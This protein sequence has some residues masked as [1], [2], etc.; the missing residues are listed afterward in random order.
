MTLAA[1][2]Q[3]HKLS[4]NA[5]LCPA[6]FNLVGADSP[7]VEVMTDFAR[8]N[9]VTILPGAS[10]DEANARMISRGVRLLMVSGPDERVEG[11]ISARDLMGEK[12]LQVALARG[13]KREDLTV[14]DLMVPTASIDTLNL[15]DVL[16]ARVTDVLNALKSQGRQHIMV[17]DVDPADGLPRVRG[18][19]SAT[20]IGR[21]LGVPVLGFDLPQTFAEIE[22]ALAN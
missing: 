9:A 2:L 17:E 5:S 22:A 10:L 3:T 11:L 4:T 20:Q 12:P 8:V 14:R 13:S 6:G 19:F 18:I 16:N 1:K 21:L 7:A 15:K